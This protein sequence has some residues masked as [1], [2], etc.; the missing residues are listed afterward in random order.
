MSKIHILKN[1]E[2]EAV[3]KFYTMESAGETLDLDLSTW[4]TTPTSMLKSNHKQRR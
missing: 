3:V 2:T 1:T 4:L